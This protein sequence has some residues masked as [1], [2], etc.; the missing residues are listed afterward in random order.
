MINLAKNG[1]GCRGVGESD[2]GD[3]LRGRNVRGWGMGC[4]LIAACEHAT[5]H[6][7][8]KGAFWAFSMLSRAPFIKP[9]GT[10]ESNGMVMET[11]ARSESA[12]DGMEWW[13]ELT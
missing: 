13:V 10:S 1:G 12:A 4:G 2:G 8:K 7:G 3:I 9:M 5:W 6:Y 11:M